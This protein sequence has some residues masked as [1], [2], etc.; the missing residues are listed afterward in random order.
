M[1]DNPLVDSIS[2]GNDKNLVSAKIVIRVT[3][4]PVPSQES[5]GRGSSDI[6]EM[7]M[8]VATIFPGH[9]L[10]GGGWG[11]VEFQMVNLEMKN[12]WQDWCKGELG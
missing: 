11:I 6:S 12:F 10:T 3:H 1:G 7:V 2:Y 8:K 9:A 4:A 5:E